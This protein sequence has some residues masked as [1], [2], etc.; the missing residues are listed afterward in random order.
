MDDA[1]LDKL[2]TVFDERSWAVNRQYLVKAAKHLKQIGTLSPSDVHRVNEM[3]RMGVT[4]GEIENE[5]AQM[6][7]AD[8]TDVDLM[9]AE[10]AK[11]NTWASQIYG[12]VPAPK[13]NPQLIN[14]VTAAAKVT[15]ASLMNLSQTTIDSRAYQNAIDKAIHA[16]STGVSSYNEQIRQAVRQMARDGLKVKYP[17]GYERRLDTAV[18]QNVLDGARAVNMGTQRLLGEQFGADGVEIDAHG[19][20]AEDHLPYQGKRFTIK[21][22]DELQGRLERPI[23]QWN[24]RHNIHYI[25]LGVSPPAMTDEE[26]EAMNES[27]T[28]EITIDGVTKTRY[29]WSQ[30]MRRLETEARYQNDETEAFKA[31]GDREAAKASDKKSAQIVDA[32]DRVCRETGLQPQYDRMYVGKASYLTDRPRA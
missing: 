8:I 25:V 19:L 1:T 30:A 16:V 4:L 32:Y 24:C 23:G 18:R 10:I 20:C 5:I 7:G 6:M 14:L 11:E 13:D 17:S 22:F 27:S 15:N 31:L 12:D 28:R 21:E 2:L 3:R 29:E 26:L 9:M